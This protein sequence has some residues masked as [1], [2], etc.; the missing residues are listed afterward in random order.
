MTTEQVSLPISIRLEPS[1]R[2]DLRRLAS[3]H[4]RKFADECRRALR[5]YVLSFNE[6]EEKP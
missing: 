5:L 6:G 2:D 1:L 3:E 4:D